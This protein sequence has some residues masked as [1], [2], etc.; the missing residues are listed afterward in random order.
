MNYTNKNINYNSINSPSKV[1]ISGDSSKTLTGPIYTTSGSTISSINTKL[2]NAVDIDWNGAQ[3]DTNTTISD[4]S[5]LLNWIK[6]FSNNQ[7]S[8]EDKIANGFYYYT[9]YG[10]LINNPE[11][12]IYSIIGIAVIKDDIKFILDIH[13][14]SLNN[15]K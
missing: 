4:T 10:E 5:D 3:V 15:A 12:S 6:T 2:V 9:E 8:Q 1:V 7:S 14:Y 13:D 11:D